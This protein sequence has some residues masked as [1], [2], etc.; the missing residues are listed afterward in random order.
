MYL[1]LNLSELHKIVA[2]SPHTAP[3]PPHHSFLLNFTVV[4]DFLFS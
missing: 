1:D 3:R 4:G 2:L